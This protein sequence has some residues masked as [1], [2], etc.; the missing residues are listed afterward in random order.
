[1]FI[2]KVE[3]SLNCQ[4]STKKTVKL[5]QWWLVLPLALT[6]ITVMFVMQVLKLVVIL[7]TTSGMLVVLLL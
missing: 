6:G 5:E 3:S 4:M 7:F 1:M 2:E